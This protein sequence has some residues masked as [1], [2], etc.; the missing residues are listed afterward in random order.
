MPLDLASARRKA[1]IEVDLLRASYRIEKRRYPQAPESR[2]LL[3]RP[4]PRGPSA[5]SN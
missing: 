3:A 4:I 2:R 1:G 5:G